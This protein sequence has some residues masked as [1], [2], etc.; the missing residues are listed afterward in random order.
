MLESSTDA[1]ITAERVPASVDVDALAPRGR[2]CEACG[3][4]VESDDRFCTACGHPIGATGAG[5]PHRSGEPAGAVSQ[6]YFRCENCGSEVA[7]DP[8][9]RSYVCPFCDSTYVVE[10]TREQSGRQPPEYV[11]G[12][13]VTPDQAQEKFRRWI[14]Q[15]AWFR[16]GNL[17]L[18]RIE[19]KLKG[20][21]LPFWSFSMLARSRWSA[22]I[23]EYWYRT[24]TYWTTDSKGKRV[25]RTRTVRETEWWPLAGG[26]HQY[27]SGYLVSGSRGLSQADADRIKPFN[28]PALNRYEPMYLAGW[29]SEEYSVPREAALEICR[30]TFDDR[31]RA[32]VAAFMPGDTHRQLQVS[33]EFSHVNSDLCLLP[34]YILSYRFG[35]KLYRFMVNGQTGKVAG[36][37]PV[38]GWRIASAVAGLLLLVGLA[39][40]L[41]MLFS[42]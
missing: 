27:Y 18:A 1:T 9:Q 8:D 11:I 23:G 36:D 41:I 19:E 24:E 3:A 29:L 25:R 21:Y 28:L 38:S 4:P 35:D 16:P 17:H 10:F 22:R 15:N 12:F 5:E 39:W 33:T 40:L 26:H 42:S 6:K 31:E 37:K 7:T 30:R 2:P 34:I 20:V 13:A 32:N 14:G